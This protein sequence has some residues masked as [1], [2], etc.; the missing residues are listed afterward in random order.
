M[1]SNEHK[2]SICQTEQNKGI[3]FIVTYVYVCVYVVQSEDDAI[4]GSKINEASRV[5]RLR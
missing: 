4:Q 2:P 5:V 1:K 3:G